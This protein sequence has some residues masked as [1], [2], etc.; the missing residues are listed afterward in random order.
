MHNLKHEDKHKHKDG[1]DY[2]S[3]CLS[4]YCCVH[5]VQCAVCSAV[6]WQADTK[7]INTILTEVQQI[8]DMVQSGTHVTP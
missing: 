3:V 2:F 7:I 6:E 5:I 4:F 1:V 8:K